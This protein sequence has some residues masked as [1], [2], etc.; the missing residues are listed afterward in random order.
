MTRSLRFDGM[1]SHT[2]A[3]MQ[4]LRLIDRDVLEE[5]SDGRETCVPTPS[6]VAPR[7]LNISENRPNQVGVDVGDLQSS[8]RFLMLLCPI[9]Q[10]AGGTC[11]YS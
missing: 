8:R 11:P 9:S 4:K 7:F 1:A 10:E 2:L 6:C 5:G 3:V